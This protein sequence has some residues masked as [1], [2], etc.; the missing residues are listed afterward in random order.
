ML[1]ARHPVAPPGPVEEPYATS[2]AEVTHALRSD[3]R[4]GLEAAEAVSRLAHYGPNAPERPRRPPYAR[5]VLNQLLDPLVLLLIGAAAVSSAIGEETDGVVIGAILVLNGVLGFWQEAGA[6]RAILALSRAFTQSALVVRAGAE[7]QIPAEQVVPGDLLLVGQG[8]RVAADARL[9]EASSLEVD[10]SALTGESLPVP[11]KV[12]AV[13]L[14]TPLAERRSMIFAGTG[15]THGDARAIV[16]ATGPATEMGGIESLAG[17]AKA[18]P[19]PLTRRLT[20]LAKLMVVVGLAITVFLGLLILFRG[21]AWNEAFLTAVAVAVAA[22]PEGLAATVTASLAIGARAMARR[23]AIVRR[24][25][26]IETL[27]ETT[28]ICTDKTGTLTQNEIRVAALRSAEGVDEREFFEAATLASNATWAGEHL[29]G[30]P[31]EVALILAAMERGVTQSELLPAYRRIE[32]LPFSSE[33]KMMT[34]V[35]ETGASLRAFTK[36][37]PEVLAGLA[38]NLDVELLA[39]AEAWAAEGLRVLAVAAREP[40]VTERGETIEHDL[41]VLGVVALHDPLRQTAAEAVDAARQAGV[42]VRML[43]GD[44]PATARTIGHAL[45]LADEHILARATPADKLELVEELQREG[46]V[47]TVTGDGVNDAPALRRA[48]VGVAMGQGG[49]EAAREASDVVLADD[50]F[51]TIIAAIAEG[52]RIGDNI[53]KFIAFLLSANFGEVLLFTSAIVIGLGSP[54]VVIQVLIVNLVT[55]GLPALALANDPSGPETMMTPP[56]TGGQL[57]DRLVWRNLLLIGTLVG[58][59]TFAAY[60]S[61]RGMDGEVAQTM[62]FATLALSELALVYGMRSVRAAAW[63]IPVNRWLNLS[64]LASAVV[65]VATIY[66]PAANTIFET[67][68][69]GPAEAII[70]LALAL[71]P[72]AGVELVKAL[73]R[74]FSAPGAEASKDPLAALHADAPSKGVGLKSS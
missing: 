23:R 59:A 54:L 20:R 3:P 55:D 68:P 18:P 7:Q 39:A 5:L 9:I 60:V 58:G 42:R 1:D 63:S 72:L 49:T 4:H 51:A 22:V 31:I 46:H 10:E 35:Y 36:G 70:V 26:A 48:D 21:G 27:G 19:T 69:L 57:F 65:V 11:K 66:V 53:R 40:A 44:H 71:L 13:P 14:G 43:T 6:E 33:R 62:A 64:V 17:L 8:E 74:R 61:G 25:A 29:V 45:G 15:A 67:K 28:V 37:A 12:E 2:A 73:R 56:R 32:E 34:V 41:R 52:R 16:C 30:D 47:V 24:L 38:T 50:D